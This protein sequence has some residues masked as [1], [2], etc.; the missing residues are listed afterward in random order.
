M[1][2][3]LKF[4]RKIWTAMIV[5]RKLWAEVAVWST[6]RSTL[7]GWHAE[8]RPGG[9]RVV[10]PLLGFAVCLDWRKSEEG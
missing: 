9:G 10:T 1:I 7:K 2:A 8:R 4:T 3:T 6:H 5:S